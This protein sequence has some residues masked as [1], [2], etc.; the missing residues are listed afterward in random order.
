MNRFH[1]EADSSVNENLHLRRDRSERRDRNFV[2]RA[3]RRGLPA[4]R[5]EDRLLRKTEFHRLSPERDPIYY[6]RGLIDEEG[7][8]LRDPDL[9]EGPATHASGSPENPVGINHA[10][11]N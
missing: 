9:T 10:A 2:R 4:Q 7:S 3:L 5:I 11:T 8:S 6:V 1:N